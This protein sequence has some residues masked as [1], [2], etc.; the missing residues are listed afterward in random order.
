MEGAPNLL[1]FPAVGRGEI[2]LLGEAFILRPRGGH[3]E[4]L[5]LLPFPVSRR[6]ALA[7]RRGIC[8]RLS[9]DTVRATFVCPAAGFAG[10]GSASSSMVA[11]VILVTLSSKFSQTITG[12]SRRSKVKVLA[13]RQGIPGRPSGAMVCIQRSSS[14]SSSDSSSQQEQL[15]HEEHVQLLSS[16]PSISRDDSDDSN[17]LIILADSVSRSKTGK[18]CAVRLLLV[19]FVDS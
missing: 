7:W 9:F 19:W 14:D 17:P 5:L 16:S 1:R 8:G 18:R 2:A 13:W 11:N 15:S 4:V 6:T 10:T 3:G 12:L